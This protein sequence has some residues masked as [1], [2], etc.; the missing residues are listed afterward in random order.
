MDYS[1][2]AP[3]QLIQGKFSHVFQN[4]RINYG[5]TSLEIPS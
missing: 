3:V 5:K 1:C 2:F 4:L